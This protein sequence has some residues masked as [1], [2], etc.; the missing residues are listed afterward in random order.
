MDISSP[1]IATQTPIPV[2]A[3]A[4]AAM[5]MMRAEYK[6][7]FQILA[8]P[9]LLLALISG[10]SAWLA[11]GADPMNKPPS[12]TILDINYGIANLVVQSWA[13]VCILRYLIL[14]EKQNGWVPSYQSRMWP[15]LGYCLLLGLM[16]VLPA[17]LLMAGAALVMPAIFAAIFALVVMLAMFGIIVRFSL[18]LPATAVDGNNRFIASWRATKGQVMRIM[19]I[20]FLAGLWILIPVIVVII[21]G[22]VLGIMLPVLAAVL[23]TWALAIMQVAI[24]QVTDALLYAH[25]LPALSGE[26]ITTHV[27]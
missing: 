16:A 10:L 2:R 3:T 19:L 11:M 15:Y 25:F 23:A 6:N 5:R 18:V 1:I 13:G 9:A 27:A 4:R 8:V 20:R 26:E 14:S 17:G 21:L 7:I 24:M 22:G 12:V